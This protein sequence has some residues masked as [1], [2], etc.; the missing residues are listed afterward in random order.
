MPGDGGR[1]PEVVRRPLHFPV[2]GASGRC[3]VSH[4]H[5]TTT[6]F[7]EGV[8]LG[9]GLVEPLIANPVTEGGRATLGTPAEFPGWRALKVFWMSLPSYQG[10]VVVR[11]T[12]LDRRGFLGF[13]NS[14]GPGPLVAAPGPSISA[15]SG[16]RTWPDTAWVRHP[17]CYAWQV[18]GTNFSETIVF[19]A[20]L[21]G[22]ETG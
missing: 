21:P 2:I 8:L 12:R 19:H 5:Q 17:G 16:Y 7:V 6:P 10:P 18:D 22:P 13:G 20:V 1:I 14:P 9:R 11:G 3:P 4:G 15:Y